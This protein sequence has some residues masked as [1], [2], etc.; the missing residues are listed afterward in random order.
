MAW[1]ICW[2]WEVMGSYDVGNYGVTTLS[3]RERAARRRRTS[4]LGQHPEWGRP[5]DN[6]WQVARTRGSD[7]A[8]RSSL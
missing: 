1:C 4:E 5:F 8:D 7:N 2:V 3:Q 6:D